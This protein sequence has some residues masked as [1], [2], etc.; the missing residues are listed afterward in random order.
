MYKYHK[1]IG[2][3]NN[4]LKALSKEEETEEMHQLNEK[5]IEFIDRQA[6]SNM[7][8]SIDNNPYDYSKQLSSRYV[9]AQRYLSDKLIKIKDSEIEKSNTTYIDGDPEWFK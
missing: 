1:I 4:L 8:K 3:K 6:E 2:T 7:Y 9:E 5:I